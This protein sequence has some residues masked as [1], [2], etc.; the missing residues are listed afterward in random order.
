[1][2][3]LPETSSNDGSNGEIIPGRKRCKYIR[4]KTASKTKKMAT[5]IT[6]VRTAPMA[7]SNS[8]EEKHSNSEIIPRRKR[9]PVQYNHILTETIIHQM[10]VIMPEVIMDPSNCKVLV[11]EFSQVAYLVYANI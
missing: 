6:L 5:P 4:K 2:K 7:K 8:E 10:R 11:Q 9:G 1:M 3:N